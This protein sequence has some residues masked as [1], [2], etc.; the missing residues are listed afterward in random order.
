MVF[1]KMLAALGVGGPSVDTVLSTHAVTPG[2][3]LTG[4]INITG[5]DNDTVI[6]YVSVGLVTRVEVESGDNEYASN[7]EFHTVRLT[8]SFTLAAGASHSLPFRI[9]VPWETPITSVYGQ[10]LA[11]MTMGVRT[12]LSVAKAVDKTDL[13]PV[14]IAPL[15]THEAIL[16][17]FSQLGFRFSRADLEQ[18]HIRG[19]QQTLPFYQEIEFFPS[20]NYASKFRQLE[21]TFITGPQGIDVILEFDKRGFL[22]GSTDTFSSYRIGHG[23]PSSAN[24][25]A[26]V[27]G[28]I[29]QAVN[30]R[31]SFSF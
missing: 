8:G 2:G 4:Q 18:G 24:W 13:D 20:G 7:V 5:G 26:I 11:G 21:V 29:S 25:P 12:E 14:S 17:A 15:P 9:D 27:D 10:H 23:D 16:A 28:W 22:G 19:T 30:K 1:K 31:G 3:V 6:E